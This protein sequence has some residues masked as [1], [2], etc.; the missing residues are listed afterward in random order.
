MNITRSDFRRIIVAI[1]PA[2]TADEDSDNTGIVVV[3]RGPHRPDSQCQLDLHCP[4]HGY[5]LED[6]TCHLHPHGWAT[7]A[8]AAYDRWDADRIIAEVNNGGDM[9]GE[10]VR[11]IRAGIPYDTVRATR[12]KQLRAEPVS[13]L[14]EQ[15]R[16]HHIGT[17]AELESEMETWTPDAKW[18]P[19]RLDALVWG[20]TYLG[21]I[22][23]QGHAFLSAWKDELAQDRTKPARTELDRL[24]KLGVNADPLLRRGCKHRFF[25]GFCVNCGGKVAD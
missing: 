13:A 2:V 23:D 20:L 21:L 3:A 25:D 17:F 6:A 24:P 18:S 4:G 8:V 5:V 12:G 16:V 1:D 22:G 10:T 14:Y 19:D 9:V 15:H 7:V 11:A